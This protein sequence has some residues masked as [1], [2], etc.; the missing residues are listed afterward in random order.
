LSDH[1]H[2]TAHEAT[3]ATYVRQSLDYA[4]FGRVTATLGATAWLIQR[5]W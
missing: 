3:D 5:A 4:Q 2:S 1:Q